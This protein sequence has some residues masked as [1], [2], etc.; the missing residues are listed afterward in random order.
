VF[1]A[2]G[3]LKEFAELELDRRGADAV[4]GMGMALASFESC[5]LPIIA[6]VQGEALGGGAELLLLCDL[7]VIEEQAGIHFRQ[8]KLGLTPAW[9]GASRLLEHV[10]VARASELLLTA[11]RV[12]AAEAVAIGL[13]TKVAR[14]DGALQAA[15]ELGAAI[16]TSTRQSVAAL[17]AA[18]NEAR[19]ARRADALAREREVFRSAWGRE[20]HVE[21]M[22]A[23]LRRD[24]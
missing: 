16:A 11:R 18:L 12:S 20:S 7:V 23:F 3:D 6:A 24:R 10:G 21:A 9:G 15:L 2:G 14:P 4:L 5:P 8:G 22:R 17:K 1:V 19:Q 13:A